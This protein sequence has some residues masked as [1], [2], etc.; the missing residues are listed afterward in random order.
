MDLNRHPPAEDEEEEDE[1]SDVREEAKGL[2]LNKPL[3]SGDDN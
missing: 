2:D 1:S 3:S